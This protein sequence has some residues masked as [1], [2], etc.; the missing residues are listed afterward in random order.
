MKI[1]PEIYMT[2]IKLHPQLIF[3]IVLSYTGV[4]INNLGKKSN[5]HR[6]VRSK[7]DQKLL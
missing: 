3:S 4:L 7:L 2:D 5:A 6:G 1:M